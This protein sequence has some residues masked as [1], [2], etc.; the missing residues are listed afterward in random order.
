MLAFPSLTQMVG[1]SGEAEVLLEQ[2]Q[3]FIKG[4]RTDKRG[5]R[6]EVQYLLGFPAYPGQEAW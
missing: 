5:R 1:S 6:S 4:K 2:P 3:A